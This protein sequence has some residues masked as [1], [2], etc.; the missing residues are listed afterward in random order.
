[1]SWELNSQIVR[2]VADSPLGPFK[3]EGVSI[4]AF[5]HNAEA[6]RDP[7]SGEYLLLH[8]GSGKKGGNAIRGIECMNGNETTGARSNQSFTFP[9][10]NTS[11][12][13]CPCCGIAGKCDCCSGP[14]MHHAPGPYGP[15][16]AVNTSL[17]NLPGSCHDDNPT[18]YIAKNGTVW[19]LGVCDFTS[20]PPSPT[21]VLRLWRANS[22]DDEFK[23]IGNMTH[24]NRKG[25]KQW[26]WVDPTLWIDNK[27]NIHVARECGYHRSKS[28]QNRWVAPPKPGPGRSSELPS[29]STRRPRR[30]T[31]RSVP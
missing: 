31:E 27:E 26:S 14:A 15:W 9:T 19:V 20:T 22:W 8:I 4:A 28:I 7:K 18:L 16:V 25:E 29:G 23:I 6:R 10:G 13:L 24:S 30:H 11:A 1:M 12:P 3:K 2:A 5:L 21:S 17:A